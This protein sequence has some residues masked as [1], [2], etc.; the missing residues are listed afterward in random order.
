MYLT[1]RAKQGRKVSVLDRELAALSVY[2]RQAG[3]SLPRQDPLVKEVVAGIRRTKGTA[4]K[5]VKPLLPADLGKICSQ[6]PDD[7]V[8]KRDKAILLVGFAGALR[9][10]EIAALRWDDVTFVE[11]GIEIRL[12]YSKTDQEGAGTKKGI[13]YGSN[14]ERCPVRALKAWQA[15]SELKKGPV[16]RSID[17]H[18][19]LGLRSLSGQ[20]IAQIL[21]DRAEAAGYQADQISGHSLRAGLVTAAARSGKSLHAIQRQT[22]HK[23]INMVTKY[24]REATLFTDNAASGIGL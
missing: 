12:R 5:Q 8:G 19:N 16:F 3:F 24:V 7:L 4:Q 10:Q 2:H 23:S 20:A 18:Q 15:A 9:R 17:R 6:T 21:K 22:G 14:P 13:P 11:D 1:D